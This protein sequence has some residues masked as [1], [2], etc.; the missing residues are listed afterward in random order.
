VSGEIIGS[1]GFIPAVIFAVPT[2][3]D[4]FYTTI[5]NPFTN[6]YSFANLDSGSYF[7]AAFQDENLNLE[8]ELGEPFGFYGGTVPQVLEVNEDLEDIDIILS[9]PDQG[10]F[11]GEIVYEGEETGPTLIVANENSDFTGT[12]SGAGFLLNN[13]GNG[14]YTA[15]TDTQA[16]FYAFAYMDLNSNLQYEFGE[17]IGIYGGAT[18][19]PIEVS[20]PDLPT[21]I[22]ITMTDAGQATP[23]PRLGTLPKSFELGVPYPNPF[24]SEATIPFVLGRESEIEILV[25]D[26]LG[27]EV[28]QIDSGRMSAGKH[29]VKF[30]AQGYSTGIYFVE[31][32]A[33]GLR[34]Q[35]RIVLIR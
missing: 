14:A 4:T 1:E 29:T 7:L 20:L 16:T 30:N 26:L 25:Y 12:P 22:D 11:S 8:P 17:P 23:K 2:S 13:E 9:T 31:L 5:E 18:P 19:Q 28:G 6:E 21:G 27:R 33:D 35:Q 24:N 3:L 10:G 34:S 15:V 32:V